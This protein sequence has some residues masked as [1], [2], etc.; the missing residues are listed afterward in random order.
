MTDQSPVLDL[1]LAQAYGAR[2]LGK[3]NIGDVERLFANALRNIPELRAEAERRLFRMDGIHTDRC[4]I[5][6]THRSVL[7]KVL[8]EVRA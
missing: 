4:I 5:T 6:A 2:L 3:G 8:K 1:Y 7:E